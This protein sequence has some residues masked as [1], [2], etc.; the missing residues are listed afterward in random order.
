MQLTRFK[1]DSVNYKKRYL[2][3]PVCFYTGIEIL[4]NCN[5]KYSRSVEH[6][7]SKSSLRYVKNNSNLKFFLRLN[8]VT[9]LK[10]INTILG[11][12]PLKVKYGLKEYLSK[13]SVFPNLTY[14]EK[15]E[16]YEKLTR[17]YI[18]K[19]KVNNVYPWNWYTVKCKESRKKL[20]KKYWRL[21][22][23][24]EK[25]LTILNMKKRKK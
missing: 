7:V 21:L 9:C 13:I 14:L 4:H 5:S 6:I 3:N 25:Q 22:T 23:E 16:V 15:C 20:F 10:I 24:E 19:Y 11:N 2:K 8:T 18:N 1:F 12:S 17:E